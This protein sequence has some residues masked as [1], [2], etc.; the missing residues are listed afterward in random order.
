MT[1]EEQIQTLRDALSSARPFVVSVADLHSGWGLSAKQ[2]VSKI[3]NAL[4]LTDSDPVVLG[5]IATER[6]RLR[7]ALENALSFIQVVGTEDS[8]DIETMADIERL[9]GQITAALANIL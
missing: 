7:A 5:I 1:T 4:I 8:D 2:A 9:S 6:T 3:D